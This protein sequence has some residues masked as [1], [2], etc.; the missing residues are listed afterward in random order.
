MQHLKMDTGFVCSIR[1]SVMEL[2]LGGSLW[3]LRRIS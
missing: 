3:L 1:P 2:I